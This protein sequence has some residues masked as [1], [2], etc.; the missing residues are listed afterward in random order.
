MKLLRVLL[1]A[2]GVVLM[3]VLVARND[4]AEIV[5][6]ITRLSWKLGVLICFPSVLVMVFDTLGWRF[7]FLH[8]RVRF[9]TLFGARLAGEAFNLTT[10]TAAVGGEAIKTWLLRGHAPLDESLL[11]VVVA[12]STIMMAQALFL[13][14]GIV[15]AWLIVLPDSPLLRTMQ[16]LLGLEVLAVGGFVLAQMQGM[17]G[18]GHGLLQRL[19]LRRAGSGETLR[20]V[21]RGLATFYRTQPRRL[22]LSIGF[23]LVAW[24]LGSVEV[25]LALHFLGADVSLTTA[26]I[27]E[28]FGTA[29]RFATFMIPASV[30]AQE[31]VFVATF[32]V[33]GLG[34]TTGVTFALTRR[35]REIAWI[36]AGLV[37]FAVMREKPARQAPRV[38]R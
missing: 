29:T 1:L 31:G 11:S 8:D 27:I 4:P 37:A 6:S 32:A 22:V 19:N 15:L 26:V 36:V 3:G 30:G 35:V 25:Y 16:W 34:S 7:A 12:K 18:R 5:A 20:Q 23:H 10:P 38:A 2:L 14:L 9:R 24:L 13:V 33:L 17:L 21:D 28:A